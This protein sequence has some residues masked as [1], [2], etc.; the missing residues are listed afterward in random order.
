MLAFLAAGSLMASAAWYSNVTSSVQRMPIIP[1]VVNTVIIWLFFYFLTTLLAAKQLG[2]ESSQGKTVFK[3]VVTVLAVYF[4]YQ[5]GNQFVFSQPIVRDFWNYLFDQEGILRSAEKL[6]V[7]IGASILITWA[8]RSTLKIGNTY[9][10]IDAFLAVL[11]AAD[12][13][14]WGMSK[15]TFIIFAQVLSTILL[16]KQFNDVGKKGRIT[17]WFWASFIVIWLSAI[18]FPEAGILGIKSIVVWIRSL[19]LAGHII[20]ILVFIFGGLIFGAIG[21]S[22]MN[23]EKEAKAKHNWIKNT[24]QHLLQRLY[25]FMNTTRI[26]M[27]NTLFRWAGIHNVVL[28]EPDQEEIGVTIRKIWHELFANMNYLLRLEVYDSKGG[29]VVGARKGLEQA[30]TALKEQEGSTYL[31]LYT[32]SVMNANISRYKMGTG[33]R[34]PEIDGSWNVNDGDMGIRK[35]F[36]SIDN[37]GVLKI[38]YSYPFD[39]GAFTLQNAIC[40][41]F[42]E[43]IG[44][45][46]NFMSSDA[47]THQE[48]QLKLAESWAEKIEQVFNAELARIEKGWSSYQKYLGRRGKLSLI[49]LEQLR[50]LLMLRLT[51]QYKHSY[52]FARIGAKVYK[53]NYLKNAA[54]TSAPK[55]SSN[56]PFFIAAGD[57]LFEDNLERTPDAP[58]DNARRI[59]AA[60]KPLVSN[61]VTED[62]YF[63]DD[64]NEIR[65]TGRCSRGYVR[66]IKPKTIITVNDIE[67]NPTEIMIDNIITTPMFVTTATWLQDEWTFFF[68]DVRDGRYHPHSRVALDYLQRHSQERKYNYNNLPRGGRP[69][70]TT[71]AFDRE[72]LKDP[73]RFLYW[74]KKE[75]Q[76]SE[77]DM[78][79]CGNIFPA[80]S[81]IGMARYLGD[82]IDTFAQEQERKQKEF[83]VWDSGREQTLFSGTPQKK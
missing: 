22:L 45:I 71:P 25:N 68:R 41:F 23:K 65:L 35:D 56:P 39:P 27:L 57:E 76:S 3:V 6:F 72:A 9:W 21:K 83:F 40:S 48:A 59:G 19:G 4:A 82:F 63:V 44:G 2:L 73:G 81:T 74:G 49:K 5:L 20:M 34:G 78:L 51:G 52:K 80:V 54:G 69:N 62:G 32:E 24:G 46:K 33:L 11:I 17:S 38:N 7:F 31:H 13:A 61:E 58:L 12:L 14:R 42:F 67:G 79:N 1:I 60:A 26:P 29:Y 28:G 10:K 64:L 16:A 77:S 37:E 36:W 18:M 66:R 53:M 8:L 50:L 55:D 75:L 15:N 70:A 47:P 43:Y 30:Y